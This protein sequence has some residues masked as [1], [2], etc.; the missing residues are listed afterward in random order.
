MKQSLSPVIQIDETKC[1][2]CHACIAACPIKYCIDGS[3]RFSH[4]QA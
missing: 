3:G 1:V 2:N 4:Y